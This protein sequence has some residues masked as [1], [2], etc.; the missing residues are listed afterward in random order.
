MVLELLAALS[1]ALA[2]GVNDR[3]VSLWGATPAIGVASVRGVSE[4]P[5][6]LKFGT[7]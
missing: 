1:I 2:E 7:H 6:E 3:D 4:I 5:S